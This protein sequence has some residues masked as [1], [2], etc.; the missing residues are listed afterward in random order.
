[1]PLDPGHRGGVVPDVLDDVQRHDDIV[2]FLDHLVRN[3]IGI[4]PT[5]ERVGAKAAR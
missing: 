4:D 5:D 1:M 3:G 2:A